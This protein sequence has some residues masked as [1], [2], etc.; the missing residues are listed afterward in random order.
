MSSLKLPKDLQILRLCT[1]QHTRYQVMQHFHNHQ[2]T[3]EAYMN[4]L[5]K[6]EL[7][8]IV[9]EEPYRTGKT[10]KWFLI[11][12]KGRAVLRGHEEAERR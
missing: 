1:Q 12:A 8:F 7:L 3:T 5:L 4:R 11:T 9:K 2:S 10:I 6:M